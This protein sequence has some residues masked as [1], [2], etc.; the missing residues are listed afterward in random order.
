MDSVLLVALHD[1]KL[2]CVV[3]AHDAIHQPI[4]L[5]DPA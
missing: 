5:V 1:F 3:L 2:L 4:A